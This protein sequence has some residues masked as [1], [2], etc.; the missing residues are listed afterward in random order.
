MSQASI[1]IHLNY[2]NIFYQFI[3]FNFDEFH[4]SLLFLIHNL[5]IFSANLI[6][7]FIVQ[8]LIYLYQV[9]KTYFTI[10]YHLIIIT[11][12][13]ILK[14]PFLKYKYHFIF[15]LILY[16]LNLIFYQLL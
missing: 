10:N 4:L 14:Y 3:I 15:T 6:Y 13:K 2:L 16:L 5:F 8:V 9:I 12:F 11:A 7:S 1:L